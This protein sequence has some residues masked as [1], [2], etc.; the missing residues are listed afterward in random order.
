MNEVAIALAAVVCIELGLILYR[1]RPSRGLGRL[2]K[3]KVIVHTRDDQS[4]K[5]LLVG[6]Y[7]SDLT[8]AEPVF[9]HETGEVSSDYKRL[10][11]PRDNVR[12][13][14]DVTA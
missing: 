8:L 6:E 2:L 13:L 4:V 11:I 9:L 12:F 7:P 3:R 10:V 1:S 14:E 5:G